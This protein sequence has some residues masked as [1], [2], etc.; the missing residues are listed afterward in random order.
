MS[1]QVAEIEARIRA[2]GSEERTELIRALIADLDGPEDTDVERTWL[3]EAERRHR[4]LTEGKVQPIPG[5]RV[6]ENLRSRLMRR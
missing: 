1:D 3:E 4:E 6:F 5:E 2:L